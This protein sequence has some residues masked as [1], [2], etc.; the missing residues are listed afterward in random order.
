M[1]SKTKVVNKP[2]GR[3]DIIGQK[4][5]VKGLD[6]NLLYAAGGLGLALWGFSQGWFNSIF[7]GGATPSGPV[8]VTAQPN[9]DP[10]GTPVTAT[11]AFNPPAATAYWGV[12]NSTG[13]LVT[14]GTI[15]QN[16]GSFSQS[17]GTFPVGNYTVTVSDSPVVGTASAPQ[18]LAI[19]QQ[20]ASNYVP[21]N[22]TLQSSGS[23]GNAP[24]SSPENL[25]L[26]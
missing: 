1:A 4:P 24:I 14:S 3:K 18:T 7:G 22:A 25:T 20:L 21:T 23:F 11:G 17:L 9:P 13:S 2:G 6:N 8:T 19:N 5:W 26:G 15:G 16:V 12:F 10:Q